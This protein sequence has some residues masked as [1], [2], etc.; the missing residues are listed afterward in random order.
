MNDK[1]PKLE[2]LLLDDTI[3]KIVVEHGDRFSRFGR[4]YIIKLLQMQ[5]RKVEIIN[6]S[7]DNK[8]DLMDDFVAIITSFC[9]R[10]YG[11]RRNKRRTEKI[12]KELS[13]NVEG[14]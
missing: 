2:K 13:E 8:S 6:E 14:D 10:L 11:L 1:R 4:N 5:G 3:S 12:I 7:E 9:A